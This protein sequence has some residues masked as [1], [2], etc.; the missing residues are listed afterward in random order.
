[1]AKAKESSVPESDKNPLTDR[2]DEMM[3]VNKPDPVIIEPDAPAKGDTPIDIF[4]TS[5]A[6]DLPAKLLKEVDITPEPDTKKVNVVSTA[7]SKKAASVKEESDEASEEPTTEDAQNEDTEPTDETSTDDNSEDLANPDTDKAVD[8]IVA[9]ESDEL[10]AVEDAR[11]KRSINPSDSSGGFKAKLAAFFKNKWTWIGLVVVLIALFAVPVTRYKV[12]GLAFK[13][14]ADVTI[15]DSKTG[16]PVSNVVVKLGSASGKT[17]ATGE[18][19]FKAPVGSHNLTITKQYYKDYSGSYF[20]GFGTSENAKVQLTATGRQVPVVVKSAITGKPLVGAEVKVLD[21]TA[22]T[23]AKG[24]ATIVLPIKQSTQPATVSLAGYNTTK[25]TIQVTDKVVTANTVKIAPTG[26]VYFMSNLSGN[27]D[28]VS[29][30]LDGSGRKVVL[31]GTGKE[32]PGTVA[33]LAS[34]D[35][36]YLVLESSR[37]SAN[38]PALYFIDTSDDSVTKFES[39]NIGVNLIGWA[40]HNFLYD[41]T[42]NS[43]GTSDA[44]RE[45]IKSYDADHQQ[46]NLLVQN[47]VDDPL[48][49]YDFFGNFNITDKELL[50]TVSWSH[51]NYFTSTDLSSHK[52]TLSAVGFT[53]QNKH[54]YDSFAG[55]TG[56]YQLR[57]Y[58][59]NGIYYSINSYVD[60]SVSYHKIEDGKVSDMPNMTSTDFYKAYPTYLLSPS[61]SK[62]FWTDY[63]DG[64]NTLFVGN[65]EGDNGKQIA[66]LSDYSPYGWFT[67]NYLLVTKNSSELYIM[68][69]SGGTPIKISDYYK[70]QQTFQGYGKGYGGL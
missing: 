40:G 22:K 12:L 36:K 16:T 39:G 6:P 64:K 18:A 19:K 43:K 17:D 25:A 1:M 69:S 21:T 55:N 20:V 42:N 34:T 13:G 51:T 4:D 35:W 27:L 53:G 56:N 32:D 28:V 5:T 15:V 52:N 2:I 62:N 61:S 30:N 47:E 26:R 31:A 65:D 45:A 33:L 48:V 41:V 44:G 9:T 60:N 50:Y 14:T 58:E 10:L 59:P 29:T 23:D 11:T 49:A 38:Q 7:G 67:D 46:T 66:T 63:R 68:P 8:D 24:M 57:Y 70:P 37:D 54:D 3:D